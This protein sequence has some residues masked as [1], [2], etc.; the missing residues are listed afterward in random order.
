MEESVNMQNAGVVFSTKDT[1]AAVDGDRELLREL[2]GMFMTECAESIAAIR[3]A[4][5]E[6]NAPGLDRAAHTLKGM[7]GNFGARAAVETALKL[8]M[9]GKQSCLGDAE[10]MFVVL[11]EELESLK[12]ALEQ[13][14][15]ET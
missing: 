2:V 4:I 14:A 6:Q 9:M 1:L 10:K 12:K 5:D 15:G 11:Q 3:K 13:F 7:V 8:E